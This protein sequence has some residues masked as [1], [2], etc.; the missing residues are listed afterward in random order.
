MLWAKPNINDQRESPAREHK[1]TKS[2]CEPKLT[3][4]K[5]IK[6]PKVSLRKEINIYYLL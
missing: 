4:P 2:F 6:K 1:E 3:K 5:A